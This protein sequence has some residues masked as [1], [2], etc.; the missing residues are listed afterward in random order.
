[1]PLSY[2]IYK[3][4]FYFYL[5]VLT[6]DSFLDPVTGH[7]SK[8]TLLLRGPIYSDTINVLDPLLIWRTRYYDN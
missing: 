8:C 4:Y 2:E 3:V 7:I 1:M 6:G 5:D